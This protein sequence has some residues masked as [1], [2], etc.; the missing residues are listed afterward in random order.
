M[1]T[2]FLPC[3]IYLLAAFSIDFYKPISLDL[4]TRV[5]QAASVTVH[6]TYTKLPGVFGAITDRLAV[7]HDIQVRLTLFDTKF[8]DPESLITNQEREFMFSSKVIDQLTFAHATRGRFS[9]K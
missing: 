6:S 5:F 1:N 3:S 4:T 9:F 7:A 2:F 8:P